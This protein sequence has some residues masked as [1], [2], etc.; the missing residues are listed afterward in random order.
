MSREIPVR[1]AVS[2]GGVVYR[3]AGD[4]TVEVVLCGRPSEK[5]W[6]LPKGTPDDGEAIEHTALR[7]VREETGLEAVIVQKLGSIDYWFMANGVR[8]HKWVHHWLME[9]TG[10]DLGDHDH[11]FEAVEWVPIDQAFRRLTFENE[12]RMVAEASR[13]LESGI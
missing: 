2:A 6:G 5:L 3:R 1:D 11:E 8:Y 9:P 10:G 7:E 4:G 13:L 12:R